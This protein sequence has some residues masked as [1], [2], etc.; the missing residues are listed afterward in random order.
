MGRRQWISSDSD[1]RLI[2]TVR[3]DDGRSVIVHNVVDVGRS[4]AVVVVSVKSLPATFI[5]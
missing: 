3:G 2:I 5:L 4:A 1:V